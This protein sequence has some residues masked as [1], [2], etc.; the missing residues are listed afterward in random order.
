M[1]EKRNWLTIP[2]AAKQLGV[3]NQRMHQIIQELGVKTT[4][5]HSRLHIIDCEEVVRI[6]RKRNSEKIA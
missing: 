4:A 3:S 6:Q 2:E 1:E 5:I